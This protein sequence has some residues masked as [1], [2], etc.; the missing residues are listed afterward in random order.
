LS[1]I[2]SGF[3]LLELVLVMLIMCTVLAM[4]AP[5]LRG[6]F[7]SRRTSDAASQIVALTQL[8]RSLAVS[9]GRIYRLNLDTEEGT[10]WLTVQ[11]GGAF[12]RIA[13]EFGRVF[14]LP[15]GTS[16]NWREPNVSS[17]GGCVQFYPDGTTEAATIRLSGARDEIV[18]IACES[19]TEFFE[20]L[21]ETE[22]ID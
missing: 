2:R 21:F 13:S 17:A 10:Y 4:A 8:A 9:E 15:D 16:A 18:D 5:S 22:A 3:T 12:V 1:H 6:F 7:S 11:Q 20:I 19:A 14:S